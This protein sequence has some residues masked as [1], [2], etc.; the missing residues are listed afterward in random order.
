VTSFA[1][2]DEHAELRASVR[3][4]LTE[5]T[6]VSAARALMFDDRDHD[7]TVWTQ[8]ATQLGLTGLSI[9]E[10]FGG[11]GFGM[12]E[13]A[14]V[15][16]E[17]GQVLL[18][19]PYFATVALATP[20]LL[21]SDDEG[22]KSAW[23]PRIAAGE[24]TAT[25]AV[26]EGNSSWAVSPRTRATDSAGEWSL[27][28]AKTFVI[29]GATTDLILVLAATDGGIG[30]FAVAG[31]A[32][33]LTR[34]SLPTFDLTRRM[35]E[36]SFTDTPARR[37]GGD[38]GGLA[39]RVHD[40]ALVALAAEQ[41]GGAQRC[42]DMAVDYAKLRVQFGRPI[43]SFQAVKHKAADILTAVET[44]RSTMVYAAAAADA[45]TAAAASG[46]EPGDGADLELAIAAALAKTVCSESFDFAAR[47]NIQIH[48]GIGFT[49]EHDA[50]L[51]LKRARAD[52]LLFDAPVYHR[53]RLGEL[54]GVKG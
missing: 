14:I 6:P 7:P 8:L 37:V 53:A 16:E 32:A 21:L 28:G 34:T 12:V 52:A 38:A 4:F 1:V 5:K 9:P 44:A 41:V 43:G 30:L 39:A 11:A 35:A 51:Y 40:L 26:G 17:M 29:D 20:A 42:L 33:G 36:V 46:G 27:S 48:G 19:S 24:L 47:Q 45:A 13:L 25:L 49:W 50:H 18:S 15:F 22:A 54:A 2:T 3:R 23:L 31:D 10:E